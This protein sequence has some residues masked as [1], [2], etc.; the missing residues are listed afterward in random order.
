ME[1]ALKIGHC[2]GCFEIHW[3]TRHHLKP[4]RLGGT[5]EAHNIVRLCRPCHSKEEG[6]IRS[7]G[8]GSRHDGEWR[9]RQVQARELDTIEKWAKVNL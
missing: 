3:L 5:N 7:T 6:V 4:Q 9:R 8:K 1:E 2:A